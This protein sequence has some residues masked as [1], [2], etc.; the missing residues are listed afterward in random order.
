MPNTVKLAPDLYT[1]PPKTAI[2]GARVDYREI[3]LA[4][5]DL[6]TTQIIALGILPAGH[7]LMDLQLECGDMDS[8]A[9]LTITVGLL[10]SYYNR[11]SASAAY[12]GWDEHNGTLAI[13]AQIGSATGATTPAEADG[14]G[15][16]SPVLA[17]GFDII[18]ASTVGQAGGRD[19][20]DLDKTPTITLGISAYDRIIGVAFPAAPAGAVAGKLAIFYEIDAGEKDYLGTVEAYEMP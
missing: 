13:P 18:T 9:G 7:R 1:N 15:G 16:V 11:R 2:C 5:T 10:N 14:E 3:N 8:G 19:E 20:I 17:T 4:T 6:I 12:P